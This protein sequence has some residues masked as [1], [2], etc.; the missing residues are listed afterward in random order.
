MAHNAPQYNRRRRRHWRYKMN[1]TL[2]TELDGFYSLQDDNGDTVLTLH[3]D[4]LDNA[5]LYRTEE[6]EHYMITFYENT[7]D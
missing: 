6:I 5:E 7:Q 1:Y 3:A 2:K 4:H